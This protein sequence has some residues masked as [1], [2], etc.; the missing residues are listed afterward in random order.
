MI[1]HFGILAPLYDRL[2]PPADPAQLRERLRLPTAAVCS[3]RAVARA[4]L[5]PP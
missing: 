1:D 4:V 2:I 5:R 3:M